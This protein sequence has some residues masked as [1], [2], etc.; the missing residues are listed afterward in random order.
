MKRQSSTPERNKNFLVTITPQKNNP[1]TTTSKQA[2]A[3]FE[4]ATHNNQTQY[5][6]T[7]VSLWRLYLHTLFFIPRSYT[8]EIVIRFSSHSAGFKTAH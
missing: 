1:P 7:A 4:I 2:A 6:I 5:K 8:F 3:V